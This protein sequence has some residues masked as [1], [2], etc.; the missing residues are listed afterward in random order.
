[1]A[2]SVKYVGPDGQANPE[3]GRETGEGDLLE[4]GR[5]YQVSAELADRLVESSVMWER[6]SDFDDLNV[7]Q[8]RSLAKERGV[9]GVSKLDREALIA[10]LR[11]QASTG[12]ADDSAGADESGG[13][14][15]AGGDES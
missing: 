3:V 11:G 14:N 10:A 7:K 9:E 6:V 8:L 5:V 4:H 1:M 15:D 2:T 12:D 13:D